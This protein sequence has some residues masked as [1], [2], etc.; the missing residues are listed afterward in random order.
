[1]ATYINRI[2]LVLLVLLG[3]CFASVPSIPQT[4]VL[5]LAVDDQPSFGRLILSSSL[6]LRSSIEKNGSYLLVR[7]RVEQ[8]FRIRRSSVKSRFIDS[9][10][11]TQ[12][13]DFYVINI[14]TS[15]N[16]G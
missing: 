9:V 11:W 7:I 3:I 1:M 4:P 8:P 16:V 14:K 12:G 5:Q 15:L 13:T 2:S 6:P 10:E